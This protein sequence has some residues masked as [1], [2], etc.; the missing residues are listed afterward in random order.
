MKRGFSLLSAIIFILVV[1]TIGALSLTL[2][3]ETA[4]QTGDL[5]LKT[6]AELLARSATEF[7]LLSISAHDIKRLGNCVNSIKGTYPTTTNPMFNIEVKIGY[8]GR[9]LPSN[10]NILKNDISNDDSN[11]T[12][13]IDTTV[14][15][16]SK[17]STESIRFHKRTI[18]RP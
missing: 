15:S 8:F 2:S 17:V 14:S 6:Q 11:I 5:Y 10:C 12:V 1:A 16:A 4:K 7:A 9:G 13:Q 3:N 18:Q